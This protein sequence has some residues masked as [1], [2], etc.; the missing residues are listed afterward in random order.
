[1]GTAVPEPASGL[2][3]V[4]GAVIAAASTVGGALYGIF[5]WL[6][7]RELARND[8]RHASHE[9]G[10]D[11]L[12][13]RVS[14]IERTVVTQAGV[15]AAAAHLE[16]IMASNSEATHTLLTQLQ[17]QVHHMTDRV[18]RLYDRLS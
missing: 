1:M 4:V 10:L 14:V 6:L 11:E 2:G 16:A 15:D 3:V 17:A 5:R 13:R 8:S 18:D 9:A 12:D 7:R